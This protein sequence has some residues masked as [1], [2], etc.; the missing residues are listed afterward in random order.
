M[1]LFKRS[2]LGAC[3]L[4]SV[5]AVGPARPAHAQRAATALV[6]QPAQSQPSTQ[7]S[8]QAV[9]KPAN[10][11][12]PVG[13][14]GPEQR[15]A[16]VI[17]NSHYQHVTQL[18]NPANDAKAIAQLLN[19]AGFEVISATDLSH[20]EMIQVMQDFSAKIAG[21]GPNTVAM[22]YYA[23][24]GVQ[25]AG[26]NYLVP[27]D[28]KIS[29]EPDLVNDSVRLI[30]VM[31]TLETIP[32]RMR[33]VILDACRNNPFPSLNDAG[34][35]LA[36]VDAPNGSIV[37]YSTAPGTEALDGAGDHS[38]YTAAFLRAAREKNQ[39]IEQ[40]FKRI[41]LDVNDSTDGRQTPWESSSLTSD[42]YFFG[43]TAVAATRAPSQAKTVYAAADL[44]SR[45]ARQAYDYV[46]AENSIENYQEYIRLYP[47]DPLC[48][49]IRALLASLVQAKAWHNAVLAN[50]AV[51]YKS[52]YEKFSNSPYAQTAL[53]L[54]AQPKI[55]PLS[56]PTHIIAP[57]SIRS[58]GFGISK[59]N[60]GLNPGTVAGRVGADKLGNGGRIL[61]LQSPGANAPSGNNAG[62]GK[63]VDLPGG[64][65]NKSGAQQNSTLNGGAARIDDR[66]AKS[67]SPIRTNQ[68]A[69]GTSRTNIGALPKSAG[70]N[71]RFAS[72]QFHASAVQP[73]GRS[74]G[75]FSR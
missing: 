31:A 3:L 53:K 34:R 16:L 50:S 42:F 24:H 48:D 18:P 73:Q 5:L 39:P 33:I 61:N 28:A 35:G 21:R 40:L 10:V 69:A 29:S 6:D 52:F 70:N 71:L 38:P 56:Q 1:S 17:G 9:Q 30:D 55:I 64:G 23:G 43:D 68:P 49:R 7:T 74:N 27:V 14:T 19:A 12:N 72:T 15:V 54:E 47:R 57:P 4:A 11:G 51:A 20:N 63:I 46:L 58:G 44:P 32:S 59:D 66:P 37:G 67:L 25:L 13:L 2:L 75:R 36:I 22:V 8:T 62:S 65:L 60:P 26:E 45:A 41:R